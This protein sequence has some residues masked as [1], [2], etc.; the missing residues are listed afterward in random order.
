[1]PVFA[2]LTAVDAWAALHVSAL[3]GIPNGS[4][5]GSG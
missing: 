4:M 2:W 3:D 1:M 5:C